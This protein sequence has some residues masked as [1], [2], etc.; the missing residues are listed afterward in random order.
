MS[1]DKLSAERSAIVI[2]VVLACAA[3]GFGVEEPASVSRDAPEPSPATFVGRAR[4]TGCHARQNDQWTGSHH[5]RAM[6]HVSADTVLGDFND[7]SFVHDGTETRFSRVG[8]NYSVRTVGPG[9][10]LTDY[11]IAFTFGVEP[12]QQY[13]VGLPGGRYQALG[14]AWD[15]R[16]ATSGGQR[17]FDLYPDQVLKPGDPLHWTG[18]SQNWNRM[19]AECHSTNLEKRYVADE[20]RYETTF[21]EIDVSCEACHGPGSR[22]AAWADAAEDDAEPA[23]GELDATATQ[24]VVDLSNGNPTWTIDATTSLATR[25]PARDSQPEVE[26][27]GRCH[28]RR[29]TL[30]DNYEFGAPLA[31]THRIALLEDGLY[32]ADGQIL[33]EV[34]VY[35]S[36]VQSRMYEAGV[37]CSDCH[38]PHSLRVYAQGNAL[39]NQCHLAATFDTPEHHFHQIGTE[40]AGCVSCHMPA[41]TY[42]VVD[43]RRDHSFRIPRPDQSV[44]LG[45]PNA[46]DS[47]HAAEGAAWA[48]AAIRRLYG[49]ERRRGPTWAAAISGARA[50]H[51]ESE[52]RL[53]QVVN[54]VESPAIVRATALELL[55]PFLTQASFGSVQE[56]LRD[57]EP[58]VRRAA[59]AALGGLDQRAIAGVLAPMLRDPNL[60]T[61]LAAAYALGPIP[62]EA[63]PAEYRSALQQA[64]AEYERTQ[65]FHA[66][67][68]EGQTNLG[69]LALV[70]SDAS[71]S[72]GHYRQALRLDPTFAPAYLNLADLYRA[73]GR[74]SEGERVLRGAIE[75]LPEEATLHHSLGLT[76]VR[77]QRQGDALAP[78]QRAAEL[79]PSVARYAYVLGVG[80]HSSGDVEGALEVLE[81]AHE[82]FPSDRDILVALATFARDAGDRER[83]IGYARRLLALSPQDPQA[84]ELIRS[85][86]QP[87]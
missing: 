20:Q 69:W 36:F 31:D 60:S 58:L 46:C 11:P 57:R 24:L 59:V 33:N 86:E 35:G 82:R 34:F 47:C 15:S 29:G 27:C 44:A 8:D 22:H 79:A 7:A 48:S 53:L 26:T 38:E 28:A 55:A 1:H 62:S 81:A 4:C 21:S 72:E 42:M 78:L 13:L 80:V 30:A 54:N 66:D 50:G 68:P 45:V 67:S 37:T 71:G 14:V 76:L 84:L 51:R 39:C 18:V 74:D 83:A 25:T 16:P 41:S 77:Q 10:E 49:D 12:L 19:C 87:P 6:Q 17:W 32:H 70:R 9:G 40:A 3:C 64:L 52:P 61:R 63:I 43:P 2:G 23:A 65:S 85:L 5:D 75:L 73:Q 56:A